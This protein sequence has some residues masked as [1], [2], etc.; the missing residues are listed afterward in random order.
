MSPLLIAA[1]SAVVYGV[2]DFV[3]GLRSRSAHFVWVSL[4]SQC[5]LTVGVLGWV[6]G[7]R[8]GTP[9]ASDLAWGMLAG[10]G[11]VLGTLML[12]RGLAAG[13]MHVAGPLS[14]VVGS[15]LPV[16]VGVLDGDRP[17]P[18]S[19]VGVALALPAVWLVASGGSSAEPD[20]AGGPGVAA[21]SGLG[22]GLPEGGRDGVVAGVGFAIF[23]VAISRTEDA[24]GGWPL[25]ALEVTAL[26]LL[27]GLALWRRP[28]GRLRDAS[29]AWVMGVLALVATVL[30]FIAVH[31]G[32][33]S[34]V[35]VVA[36]LYP[37][38]TVLLA[39]LVLHERPSR[40]QV[41]GLLLAAASVVLIA[42][43]GG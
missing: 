29:G 13:A 42:G 3:G 12:M 10:V 25:V 4:V 33:L 1:L 41:A 30:Y 8:P 24:S 9:T 38:F 36:S 39:M 21:A 31:A 6:V 22:R 20:V 34:L 2:S 37:A 7:F 28:P 35:V 19:W 27:T 32:M 16:L 26:I 17:S 14:A 5:V 40:R 11:H 15:A 18:L 43:A 23:F